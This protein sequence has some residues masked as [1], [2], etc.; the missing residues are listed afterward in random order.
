ML[1]LRQYINTV[2]FLIAGFLFVA[3]SSNQGIKDGPNRGYGG[4][5]KAFEPDRMTEEEFQLVLCPKYDNKVPCYI[6][7]DGRWYREEYWKE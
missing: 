7:P 6:G 3:C 5:A 1:S 4:G 2:L